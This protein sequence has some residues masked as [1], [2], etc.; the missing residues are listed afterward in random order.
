MT[1]CIDGC[2]PGDCQCSG[3]PPHVHEW[4]RTSWIYQMDAGPKPI[5]RFETCATCGEMRTV[6]THEENKR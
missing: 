4:E 2:D 1:D 3:E 5:G 6:M